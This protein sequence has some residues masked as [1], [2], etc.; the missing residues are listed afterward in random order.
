MTDAIVPLLDTVDDTIVHIPGGNIALDTPPTMNIEKQ[1]V[2][3][4]NPDTPTL[5]H[6]L[7]ESNDTLC[8]IAYRCENALRLRWYL[9]QICLEDSNKLS[10]R[11]YV[12]Y[13]FRRHSNDIHNTD[14]KSRYWSDWYKTKWVDDVKTS[15]DYGRPVLVNHLELCV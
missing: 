5:F 6:H 3:D 11:T 10:K 13:M 1:L 14:N 15:V 4:N 7:T 9:V 2:P 8:F 12:I